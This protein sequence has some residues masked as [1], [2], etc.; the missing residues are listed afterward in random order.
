MPATQTRPPVNARLA[1]CVLLVSST[2]IISAAAG[3]SKL[4][5]L[6][7]NPASPHDD[8]R[9]S[10]RESQTQSQGRARLGGGLWCPG[11]RAVPILYVLYDNIILFLKSSC[12]AAEVLGQ[13]PLKLTLKSSPWPTLLPG[14]VVASGL[15]AQLAL[16]CARAKKGD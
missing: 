4:S 6:S 5:M 3:M 14:L 13:Y 9:R 11:P 8:C 15:E 1:W 16:R 10:H 2:C 12:R 7:V